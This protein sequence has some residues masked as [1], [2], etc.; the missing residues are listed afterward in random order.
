M[1]IIYL[2]SALALGAALVRRIPFP[3]YRFEA[4]AMAVVLGLF[5][6]TW[7]AF[8]AVL[9]L[10]YDVALPLVVTVSAAATVALWSG[11][12]PTWR[13][14]EGGR[15]SWAVWGVASTVTG[16]LL[17][18]L[19]WTHS[20]LRDSEGIWSA[21]PTWAD[22][23]VHASFINHI[24]AASSLPSGMPIASGEK[25]TYPFLIDM[26]SGLYI[27]G[28]MTLHASLFWPG[29]LLALAVCQLL[30]AFGLRLFERISVAV[31]GLVLALSLGS[32]AGAWVAWSDWRESGLGFFTFLGA[33]PKDYTGLN[34]PTAQV[35]NLVVDAMI[36]Q[37]AILFGLGI[38]L[39][40]L[41][42]LHAARQREETKL[43]WPAALLI[44]LLPMAHAH[45]F[46]IT[47]PV[48]ATLAAE[49]A[50]RSRSIP[51][52][53]LGPIALALVLALPQILW[54]QSA[55]GR[56][57]G[58]RFRLG[59]MLEEGQALPGY[60]WANFGLMGLALL[61]I[62]FVMRK[63][64][65]LVW[66]LPMLVILAATQLY[67]FQPFEYDNVKLI[68]WVYIIGGFFIAYMAVELVRRHR[69]W[70]ALLVPLG[71]L[72]IVPGSLAIT[73]EFQLRD[74][75]ASPSDIEL[76]QWVSRNTPPDAVFASADKPNNPVATLAGRT[77]VMGYRGWLFSFSIPY[78]ERE[79]AVRAGFAGRFDDPA[80]KKFDADYLL[81]SANE[82]TSWGVD[83]AALQSRP[84]AW[85]NDAWRV[86]KLQ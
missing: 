33:L 67:A 11:S 50:W 12:R 13:A 69:A 59:W 44:G 70:L 14:L 28:G 53:Y 54:Q 32:A 74:Q 18:R 19:F 78:D 29:L 48:L 82:D 34:D 37:R 85:S 83:E 68:Q 58:G 57:T 25:M 62:P 30:M 65:E 16:V 81:I 73:R 66:F 46:I 1:A 51:K 75:F 60:W 20:L 56:G 24:A 7:L 10:S 21:G 35:T 47:L 52:A 15:R 64:R 3:L 61:A 86:Y 63:H 39:V 2:L 5:S 27:Q 8:L 71:V 23:G 42:L 40:V 17:A 38:G 72:V 36:P 43:L 76:A 31:I 55:N 49:A 77:V 45:T 22:Y 26:L 9:V 84:V 79:T 4:V 80:L 6:W 41:I